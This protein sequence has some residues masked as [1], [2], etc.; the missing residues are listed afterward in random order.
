MLDVPIKNKNIFFIFSNSSTKMNTNHQN[1]KFPHENPKYLSLAETLSE[2]FAEREAHEESDVTAWSGIGVF[3]IHAIIA[4]GSLSTVFYLNVSRAEK[5]VLTGLVVVLAVVIEFFKSRY[6]ERFFESRMKVSDTALALEIRRNHQKK[7]SVNQ[8]ILVCFWS[9]SALIFTIGGIQYANHNAP[10]AEKLA[11]DVSLQASLNAKTNALNQ[12][13]KDGASS[14]RLRQLAE[15]QTKASDAWQAHTARVDAQNVVKAEGASNDIWIWAFVAILICMALELGL[16]FLRGFHEG[17][18]YEMAKSLD[19]MRLNSSQSSPTPMD[20]Q[21]RSL[22][23]KIKEYYDLIQALKK[24]NDDLAK[25][26]SRLLT[27]NEA[28]ERLVK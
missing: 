15:D 1:S 27:V 3:V 20:E 19:A 2:K 14:T 22:R 28:L 7:L 10:E 24:E 12:A 25:E 4:L 5:I 18:Q 21:E 23:L 16:F 8:T 9:I 6:M 17:K 13:R 11:Y 26:N